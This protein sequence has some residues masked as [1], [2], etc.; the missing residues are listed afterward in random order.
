MSIVQ[1]RTCIGGWLVKRSEMV[2]NNAMKSYITSNPKILGGTPVIA[3]TRVPIDIILYRLKE[4]YTLM[5]IHNM[6]RHL[7]MDTLKK[8]IDEIA[9]KLPAITK[10][11][12]AVL[13]A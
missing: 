4:G 3:G 8:V 11:D 5:E 2:Y 1:F 10:D 13:Q 12:Q 9:Y 7:S 6:Y